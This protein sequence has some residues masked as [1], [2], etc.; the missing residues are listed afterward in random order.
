MW[1]NK[2]ERHS[3][4]EL[5]VEAKKQFFACANEVDVFSFV[6]RH[7]KTG[8][9]CAFLAGIGAGA[10]GKR[11]EQLAILPLVIQLTELL[12]KLIS[13]LRERP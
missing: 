7:P 12:I 10:V 8:I 1:K 11:P 5:L 13:P 2:A 3:D 4:E 9:G 6:K